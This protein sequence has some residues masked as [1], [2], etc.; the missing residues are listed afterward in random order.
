MKQT[1]SDSTKQKTG[2]TTRR[3]S[4]KSVKSAL[5]VEVA[6]EVCNQVGGIYTVIRSKVPTSV[7]KW[8]DNFMTNLDNM[9]SSIRSRV[10]F[11]IY[12]KELDGQPSTLVNLAGEEIKDSGKRK[13]I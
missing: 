11:A 2:L 7:N 5:L 8:G 6:W 1:S 13:I 10:E 4:K 12:E 3:I 9:Y